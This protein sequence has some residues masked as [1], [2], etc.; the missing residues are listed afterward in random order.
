MN[1]LYKTFIYIV[2]LFLLPAC[3]FAQQDNQ[4][5]PSKTIQ[6]DY[7][8]QWLTPVGIKLYGIDSLGSIIELDV[9][10]NDAQPVARALKRS[11]PVACGDDLIYVDETNKLRSLN[12][13]DSSLDT[14]EVAVFSMPVCLENQK[15]VAV[16]SA[17]DLLL[18]NTQAEVE[19]R[20]AIDALR[21]AQLRLADIDKDGTSEIIVLTQPTERY[22]HGVLGDRTEAESITVVDSANWTVKASFELPDPFVFEQLR[23]E[24]LD[25]GSKMLILGTRSS[26]QTGAGV[27]ALEFQDTEL[28]KV[29]EAGVIGLGNRWLNLFDSEN[30]EAYAI[31]T[32]HI[33]GPL[34]RYSFVDGEFKFISETVGVTNHRIGSR[35]LDLAALVSVDAETTMFV[36]PQY[37]QKTLEGF[38]CIVAETCQSQWMHKMDDFLTSNIVVQ[39]ING[40]RY[41]IAA[42]QDAK[43]YILH[44]L[45]D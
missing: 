5:T 14:P 34:Q 36:A 32:P 20:I 33:G 37:D 9:T 17:G 6:L 27:I 45:K 38:S 23:A 26:R 35:N 31:K 3:S 10:S 1:T 30:G 22:G 25:T 39:H 2:L 12:R 7:A 13:L 24:V 41:V 43:L 11:F 8:I 15:I 40:E 19:K 29:G 21:D 28:V 18:I 16:D 42:D 4:I 44:L